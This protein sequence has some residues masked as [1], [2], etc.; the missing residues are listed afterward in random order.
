MK[1]LIAFFLAAIILNLILTLFARG[2]RDVLRDD[3]D[4]QAAFNTEQYRA[5]QHMAITQ[6][7]AH[8]AKISRLRN[9]GQVPKRSAEASD[10]T[11]NP[12]KFS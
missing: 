6:R 3:H 8:L 9:D 11:S 7:K 12:F 10:H 4:S 1:Y 2:T 5:Q